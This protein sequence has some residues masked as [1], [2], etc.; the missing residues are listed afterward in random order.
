MVRASILAAVLLCAAAWTESD[1]A[2]APIVLSNEKPAGSFPVSAATVTSAPAAVDISVTR[3]SN[4]DETALGFYVYLEA[5]AVD[6]QAAP[7]VLVGN[8]S[9]Y[10]ADRPAGFMLPV[11]GALDNLKGQSRSMKGVRLILEMRRLH[12]DAPWK[13]VEVTIAPPHWRVQS[14]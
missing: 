10:P 6:N 7:R 4:P 9:L 3:V 14:K 12:G 2:G 11:A 1:T 13:E 8:F 5:S